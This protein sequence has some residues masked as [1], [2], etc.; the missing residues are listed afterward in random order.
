MG[1][2]VNTAS[3]TVMNGTNAMVVVKVRL[4]AVR[5]S[6][7]SR[8]RSRRVMAASIQGTRPTSCSQELNREKN[9]LKP[10]SL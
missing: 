5:P 9:C 7:S 10:M 4:L 2:A 8:K 3:A 6:R 1:K